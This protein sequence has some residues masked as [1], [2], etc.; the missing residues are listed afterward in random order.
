MGPSERYRHLRIDFLA[1]P[2]EVVEV[3]PGENDSL[4]RRIPGVSFFDG[5]H[6]EGSIRRSDRGNQIPTL[7]LKVFSRGLQIW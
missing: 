1:K 7:N 3:M 2:L 6:A 5:F 4:E